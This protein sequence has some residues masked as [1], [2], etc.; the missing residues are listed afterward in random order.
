MT[1][2]LESLT[3]DELEL[4]IGSGKK[5]VEKWRARRHELLSRGTLAAAAEA[6]EWLRVIRNEVDSLAR[7]EARLSEKLQSDKGGAA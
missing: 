5:E 1:P 6:D 4:F 7:M 3:C 2:Y